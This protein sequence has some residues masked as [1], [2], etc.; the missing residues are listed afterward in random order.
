MTLYGSFYEKGEKNMVEET[1]TLEEYKKLMHRYHNGT[2]EDQNEVKE[3]IIEDLDRFIKSII[4][5]KYSSFMKDHFLE[6][7]DESVLAIIEE[8]DKYDPEKY[9]T[10]PTTFFRCRIFN[11][12]SAFLNR[13]CYHTTKYYGKQLRMVREAIQEFEKDHRT[14][15]VWTISNMTGLSVKIVQEAL[16]EL[17]R[18]E[19]EGSYLYDTDYD[20]NLQFAE[21]PEEQCI[22]N[23]LVECLQQALN[24]LDEL[25]QILVYEKYCLDREDSIANLQKLH[26]DMKYEEI[27]A[28]ISR[29]LRKLKNNIKLSQLCHGENYHNKEKDILN[30]QSIIYFEF[31]EAGDEEILEENYEET[32][33]LPEFMRN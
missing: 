31:D 29:A 10:L 3:I 16:E 33:F 26:P 27:R 1:R 23:E 13:E 14:Y 19:Q 21:S 22:R 12:L 24:E 6:M 25:D 15:D 8:L 30:Q 9:E 4:S 5:E 11:K 28:R 7:Y 32:D 17:H 2:R 18:K 20:K